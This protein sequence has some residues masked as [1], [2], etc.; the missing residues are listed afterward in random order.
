M[1]AYFCWIIKWIVCFFIIFFPRVSL[2]LLNYQVEYVFLYNLISPRVNLFLLNYQVECVFLY[3]L[4]IPHVSLF[5]LNYPVDWVFIIFLFL[6]VWAYF[7]WIIK[8]D[9]CFFI[10]FFFLVWAYFCWIIK[11]NMCFL[12]SYFSS[13][14]LIFAELSSGMCVSFILIS[15]H[16]FFFLLNYQVE[17]VLLIII[18]L[19]VWTYFCWIIKLN[20]CL[21]TILFL[22]MWAYFFMKYRGKCVFFYNFISPHVSLFFLQKY[23]VEYVCL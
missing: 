9:V 14:E 1:W 8:W 13:C 21:S 17:Y 4:I 6:L 15:P 5:L 3:I 10:I 11:W 7:C 23:Q 20:A 18:F 16:V 12:K 19:F 2:F 22:L